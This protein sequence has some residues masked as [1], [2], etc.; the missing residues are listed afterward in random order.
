MPPDRYEV[1]LNDSLKRHVLG[2][3]P[4]E[5][6]R[7]RGKFEFLENGLWDTGVRV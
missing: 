1:L 7:L 5:R 2:L 3:E 4:G 6:R